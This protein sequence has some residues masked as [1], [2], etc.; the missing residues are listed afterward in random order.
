MENIFI[1]SYDEIRDKLP[2]RV[3]FICEHCGKQVN[4]EFRFSTNPILL[5]FSCNIK[6]TK[7]KRTPEQHKEAEEKRKKTL[8]EK[9]GS[10]ENFSKQ[11]LEKRTKTNMEK[12]GVKST[13]QSKQFREKAKKT[14]LK[15]YGDENY[16]NKEKMQK[17]MVERYGA[18]TTL[19]SVELRSKVTKT[20]KEL[21]GEHFEKIVEKVK[22]TKAEKYGDENYNNQEKARQTCLN[23]YGVEHVMK[24]PEIA[25]KALANQLKTFKKNYGCHFWKT[26]EFKEK[27]EAACLEKFG[28]PN[29]SQTEESRHQ[30]FQHYNYNGEVFDSSWEL[31]L[32]IYAKDHKENI[33]H[34]PEIL[35]YEFEGKAYRYFP[36]FRYKGKL[37]EVK[38]DHFF[39]EVGEMIDPFSEE[40]T[41]KSE[42][43]HQCGLKNGVIFYKNAE[44]KPFLEYVK[45]TYGKD[46]LASFKRAD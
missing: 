36:D 18:K 33:A 41:G 23:K 28:V 35:E 29:F 43:K 21:Y 22:Q 10:F 34:E 6:N 39:N 46:Y 3:N 25:D 9:H 38:G 16:T 30:R 14:K 19:E 40:Q 8:I 1:K 11:Q 13:F 24:V 31:A 4:K 44:V 32:W 2:I 7:S 42:A 45:E 37:I 27:A 5:C 12:Y 15:K 26:K 17:T 20:K